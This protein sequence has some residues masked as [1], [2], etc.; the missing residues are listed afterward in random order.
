MNWGGVV[1]SRVRLARNAFFSS[2]KR[3]LGWKDLA[4]GPIGAAFALLLAGLV[5]TTLCTIFAALHEAGAGARE[6][7][8]A[9][10][11]MLTA[12]VAGLLVFDLHEAVSILITDSDLELLR[13]APIPP[14]AILRIKLLDI[15]PRTSLLLVVLAIP[16]I[17]AYQVFYPLPLWAWAATPLLL[18]SLWAIPFGLG[19]AAAFLLLA[20]VPARRAREALGLISTLTLLLLWVGNSFLL[21]RLIDGD[22]GTL[23]DLVG[24][25]GEAAAAYRLS[26]GTWA[27]DALATAA[28]G[29]PRGAGTALFALLAAAALALAASG[30]AA[31]ALLERVLG[32]IAAGGTRRATPR[33][34]AARA[35]A[36]EES[37]AAHS[38]HGRGRRVIAALLARDRRLFLRDWTLLGDIL[39]AAILWTLLPLVGAPL[40]QARPA[41]LVLAMLVALSVGLGYEIASRAVPFE[42]SGIV[43]IRLAPVLPRTWIVAKLIGAALAATPIL[44]LAALST[45]F[46]FRLP[47]R[48]LVVIASVAGPALLL[49]LSIGIW[50][51]AAFG[52]ED[53]TNPRAMLT[54]VGRIVATTLLVLQAGA[55]LVVA[56]GIDSL[57]RAGVPGAVLVAIPALVA[58]V[59]AAL[60]LGA[61]ASLVAA[62][63]R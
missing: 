5:C 57:R 17:V 26:P 39:A 22:D 45:V 2:G 46:A 48:E 40:H 34:R 30:W 29:D 28:S 58:L 24:S 23:Q 32:R 1:R 33:T 49:A 11:I 8:A 3:R 50:T 12:T 18:A 9:L 36:T 15:V 51:G 16:A 41:M 60:P 47:A 35:T 52:R 31:S 27:A 25:V 6:S 56:F 54:P 38:P 55:W 19:A 42:R 63:D 10:A 21:P 14:H 59:L 7:G 43:W 61:A 53:W 20:A 13:R 44:L 37:V 4:R 62:R